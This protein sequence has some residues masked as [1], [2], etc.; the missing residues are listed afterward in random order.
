M[1]LFINPIDVTI[2]KK[3]GAYVVGFRRKM[4]RVGMK[5]ILVPDKDSLE[6]EIEI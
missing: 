2:F 6:I 1:R 3:Y 4:K 5:Q